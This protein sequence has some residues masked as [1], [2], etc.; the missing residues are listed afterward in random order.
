MESFKLIGQ[1]ALI[2]TLGELSVRVVLWLLLA[3]FV[4][5]ALWFMTKRRWLLYL[6]VM[7]AASLVV[8][9]V[10]ERMITTDREQLRR[11]VRGMAEA[12][13]RNDAEALKAFISDKR[14]DIRRRADQELQRMTIRDCRVVAEYTMLFDRQSNPPQAKFDFAV[15]A[16]ADATLGYGFDGSG[17]VGVILTF[18]QESTGRWLVTDYEIYNPRHP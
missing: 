15:H 2:E 6:A 10:V 1:S 17:T 5:G 18:E 7:C 14:P 11:D 4:L 3:V 12:V 8:L 16:A 9:V 13:R